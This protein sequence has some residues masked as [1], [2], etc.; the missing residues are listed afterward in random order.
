LT[1]F[2]LVVLGSQPD[3]GTVQLLCD[4]RSNPNALVQKGRAPLLIAAEKNNLPLASALLAA[5][6]TVDIPDVQASASCPSAA[7]YMQQRQYPHTALHWVAGNRSATAFVELLVRA[8]ANVNAPMERRKVSTRKCWLPLPHADGDPAEAES[9]IDR[10]LKI[11]DHV[12]LHASAALEL[13]GPLGAQ[14]LLLMEAQ[15]HA[16]KVAGGGFVVLSGY[17]KRIVGESRYQLGGGDFEK[18]PH[19]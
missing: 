8:K 3:A 13:L 17:I 19:G 10:G 14:P 2:Q 5:G 12:A 7:L 1:A 11:D 9:Q 6:A 18:N 15:Q 16:T 4:A